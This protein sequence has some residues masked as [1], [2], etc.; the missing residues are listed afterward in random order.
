M[1][2][3]TL[4]GLLI[5][6]HFPA[7]PAQ[8]E[9]GRSDTVT[10]IHL[11][12]VVVA[13]QNAE[14]QIIRVDLGKIPV[15]TSQDILRKVPG[16]FIA[17]HAGGGKAEQIF[18]RGYDNDHGT[19]IRISADGMPVNMVSH[20]HGQGYSDLHFLIPETIGNID[21][22]KGSYYADKG[23]F[24]TAGFVDFHTRRS[25]DHNLLKLEGGNFTTLRMV[26]IFSLL[27]DEARDKN[28]YLASEYHFTNGPF[29]VKQ[30]FN[31]LNLFAK[32]NQRLDAHSYVN[33]QAS[34]FSSGWNASGQIPERAVS[35]GMIGRF[36]SI[37][38]TEGGNTTRTNLVVN[39]ARELGHG[40]SLNSNFYYSKYKFTL[41]SNFTFFLEHPDTGD[42]IRQT[43]DRDVYGMDHTYTRY[44]GSTGNN[45]T[46]K[47]GAGFRYDDIHDL[48]LSY[49]AHREE[50]TEQLASGAATEAN[51]NAFTSV[52]W[53]MKRWTVSSG[54]RADWFA[55]GYYDRLEPA[56]G[57]Q[58][59]ETMRVSPKLAFYFDPGRNLRLFLK[60]GKGFH[61]NDVRDAVIRHGKQVLPA[62]Y[63]T[64]LGLAWQ[65][66]ERL[67]LQP[68]LW[69][70]FMENEFVWNGDSYGVSE[71]GRTRRYGADLTARYQPVDWL[72]LDLDANYA[73]PRLADAPRGQNYLELAPVFTSTGGI[74]VQ[75]PNGL[76]ANF[77]YRYMH[78]RP[79]RDDNSIVADGY[80]VNDLLIGYERRSW[81]VNV[82]VQ[83]LFDVVWNEAMFAETTRLKGERPTGFEQLTFTPGTPLFAKLAFSLKF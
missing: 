32:Y 20:A 64:D 38:S 77:R 78:D 30:R 11:K 72:Y 76:S 49:V 7:V 66:F 29:D 25:V 36:G 41:Y 5:S 9:P 44:F 16:L 75:L 40:A 8:S 31:R 12:D 14:G 17:Q 80:L 54:I 48:G 37:D 55:F 19:D 61:S 4:A 18:L 47:S 71:A 65:P 24:N 59:A 2:I 45:V 52:D 3:T 74:S 10:V 56:K 15:N 42:A 82:Q 26:G 35:E 51:L 23:D 70:S 63:G 83:N 50:V 67:L 1:K 53:K 46:W 43:D 79:A 69:Y 28:A 58:G 6:I 13:G 62:S 21:F 34:T 33:V 81:A 73:H 22:G 68:A 27:H 39:Y 57:Q 60:A